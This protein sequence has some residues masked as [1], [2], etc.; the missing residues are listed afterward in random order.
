VLHCE[1]WH[2]GWLEEV[3]TTWRKASL[4]PTTLNFAP[5]NLLKGQNTPPKRVTSLLEF[6]FVQKVKI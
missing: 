4:A 3:T 5:T 2:G 6:S 1:T